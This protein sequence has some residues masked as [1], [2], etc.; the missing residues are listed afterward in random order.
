MAA[1]DD[2]GERR[3]PGAIMSDDATDFA[4]SRCPNCSAELTGPFCAACGQRQIDIDRPLREIV[5][6]AIDAFFSFDARIVWTLVPLL[7]RPGKLTVEFLAGRRAR[8]V[9]PFKLYF[10]ISV[11]F[12]IGLSLSGYSIVRVDD[13]GDGPV[14]VFTTDGSGPPVASGEPGPAATEAGSNG[15]Q[16][17]LVGRFFRSFFELYESDPERFNEVFADRLAKVMIVLVPVFALVLRA[18]FRRR[19]YIAQLVFSLHLHSFAFL[20]VLAGIAVD[21]VAGTEQGQGWGNALA[22]TAIAVYTFLALR[23]FVGQG[24]LVTVMKMVVLLVLYLISLILAM[25]VT[26]AVTVTTM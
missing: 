25:A 6:E 8:Y 22:S 20:V 26:L 5:G 3:I 14:R 11:L 4:S 10:A 16:N 9:H 18:L 23:R 15:D 24:R 21:S 2:G 19:R 7:S 12:F 17:S 1:T 13:E